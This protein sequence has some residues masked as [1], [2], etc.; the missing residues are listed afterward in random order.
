MADSNNAG[1]TAGAAEQ[2][3][4]SE[5]DAFKKEQE[6][7]AAVQWAEDVKAKFQ[8]KKEL[9]ER[10]LQATGKPSD[11]EVLRKLDGTIKKNTAFV[12]K[13]RTLTEQQR[14]SLTADFK[15]LNLTKY[16]TE[17]ATSIAE[18]KL[19]INDVGCAVH[20]CSL[21]HQRYQEFSF[22]LMIELQKIYSTGISPEEDKAAAITK[23][24]LGLRLLGELVVVGVVNESIGCTLLSVMFE[25]VVNADKEGHIFLPVVLSFAR[26][27]AEDLAGI[28]PRNHKLMAKQYGIALPK[29]NLIAEKHQV[30]FRNALDSYFKSL[31]QCVVK[32]HKER[33]RQLRRDRHILQSK[34][35]LS[36]EREEE[37]EAAQTSYDKLLTNAS[38]L[39]EILDKDMPDLPADH[40]VEDANPMSIDIQLPM[41]TFSEEIFDAHSLWEDEDVRSFYE[42]V[43]DIKPFVP[44]ILLEGRR[45]ASGVEP[46]S[47]DVKVAS[48]GTAAE[49][50]VTMETA[51]ADEK[52]ALEKMI[53]DTEEAVA[54]EE[55]AEGEEEELTQEEEAAT[56]V[57]A[58]TEPAGPQLEEL[59]AR[60]PTLMNRKFVDEFAVDFCLTMNTKLNRR[61][62]VNALFSVDR[63][64]MDLIPFYSRLVAT[65]HPCMEDVAALLV[66]LLLKE[67]RRQVK[68]KDQIHIQSKLKNVR[69]IAELTK[70]GLCAKPETMRCM[71]ML[72]H[73]FSHHNIEMA[74][75]LMEHCGRFLLRSKDSNLRA[76]ALLE[77]MV[78]KKAVLILDP[79]QKSLIENA[80]Y[81]AHPP[82]VTR[83]PLVTR[84]PWQEYVR[85]ILY[86][87][88]NKVNTEKVLRQIRKFNWNDPETFQ[89]LVTS[90]TEIWNVKFNNVHCVAN[91]L[92]GLKPYQEDAVVH[93]V[94]G[95]LED[96]RLG[97]EVN[98]P[99]LNQR[100][101]SCVKFL[102]ELFNYQII[103][104]NVIFRTLY[105]F[106]TFGRNADGSPSPLDPYDSYFRVRLICVLLDSCGQYF[107]RGSSKKKL[108]IF[109]VFF[110]CYLFG[111]RRPLPLE[112]E[113]LVAD[114][115]ESLRPSLV[116]FSSAEKAGEAALSLERQFKENLG[117]GTSPDEGE[118]SEEEEE[119]PEVKLEEDGEVEGAE[120]EE[121]EEEEEE[122]NEED[123]GEGGDEDGLEV[124]EENEQDDD[125]VLKNQPQLVPCKEDDEFQL[126]FDK[127]MAEELQLRRTEAVKVRMEVAM[128]MQCKSSGLK[129]NDEPLI[130]NGDVAALRFKVM[131]KKGNRQQMKEVN[132]PLDS[133]LASSLM[134]TKQAVKHEHLE[135]KKLVLDHEKRQEE[136]ES[137]ATEIAK[138]QEYQ[139]MKQLKQQ[140]NSYYDQRGP[141]PSEQPYHGGGGR[142]IY[143]GQRQHQGTG[144]D[145]R[146][147]PHVPT[148]QQRS[149]GSYNQ[150]TRY[151]QEERPSH[152]QHA[153]T[154]HTQGEKHSSQNVQQNDQDDR[155]RGGGGGGGYR[156]RQYKPRY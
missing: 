24:R 129:D 145:L 48:D 45:K 11:P 115:L 125:F 9:R 83:G 15:S 4:S 56:P 10:N 68:K 153:P 107:D 1:N 46:S 31:S 74:C 71:T 33:Q 151:Q 149:Q 3:I 138:Q 126:A 16:I 12:K 135:M 131:L 57:P 101:I 18:A 50:V 112:V 44:A 5:Q 92:A 139:Q 49:Q 17:A 81:S 100:R 13:L 39:A 32:V 66:D 7:R 25:S 82:D 120:E 58:T 43:T 72:L 96:I 123:V 88:L 152:N 53:Q 124:A 61:K 80:V 42:G 73:D 95:L 51:E 98:L 70:F 8:A 38:T 99:E 121:K 150:R 108:D 90:L 77:I 127:M 134:D 35:E 40:V 97:M 105:S 132:I 63:N 142:G 37:N 109:L 14:D 146:G 114:T 89:Y 87:D 136:E 130:E 118:E 84:P 106:L 22:H 148:L 128:P 155:H 140:Q 20:M 133:G 119:V 2:Q 111:K 76:R 103:E 52:A 27:C 154:N 110:Q 143:N 65:L 62:L 78:R 67:F 28:V 141:P 147:G 75:M 144:Q 69:F 47:T 64:R 117:E 104:S 41:M 36:K 102:G 86:K 137:R 30:D 23:Y 91:L 55:G 79:R 59:L 94:D 85:T 93:V 116:L 29:S 19:K 113:H 26:H 54:M 21:L 60:L 122:G 34:G 6:D 156:Q